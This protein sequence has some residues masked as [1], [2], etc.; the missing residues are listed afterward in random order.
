MS[1]MITYI[2]VIAGGSIS[3]YISPNMAN[4]LGSFL[5]CV[6]GLWTRLSK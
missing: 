1:M 3:D 4:I 2:A 6:I 5:L